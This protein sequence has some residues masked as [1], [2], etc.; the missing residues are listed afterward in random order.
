MAMITKLPSSCQM[1]AIVV[2]VIFPFFYVYFS[3]N[4]TIN[5]YM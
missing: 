5:I 1:V 3:Y 2:F 4:I